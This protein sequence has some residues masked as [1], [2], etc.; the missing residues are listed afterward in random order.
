[1]NAEEPSLLKTEVEY[2]IKQLKANKSPGPD[3]I[4]PEIL[5]LISEENIDLLVAL[6]NRIYETGKI[7]QEWSGMGTREALFSLL[8]L[9]QKC[10]DQQRDIFIC[11]IDFEKAFDRVR[12]DLLIESLRGVG[13][14]EKDNA[15]IQNLYCNQS[16]RIRIEGSKSY[17][18]GIEF[19]FDRALADI[20]EGVKVNGVNINSIRYADDTILIADS[21]VG[22]QRLLDRVSNTCEEFDMKIN[23]KKT[24][25]I[26]K[27]KIEGK[28]GLGRKKLSRLRNIL[29]CDNYK[30][31]PS[32]LES[33]ADVVY[34][35]GQADSRER[36][37]EMKRA[38]HLGFRGRTLRAEKPFDTIP[39]KIILLLQPGYPFGLTKTLRLIQLYRTLSKT[40]QARAPSAWGPNG[41]RRRPSGGFRRKRQSERA[42]APPFQHPSHLKFQLARVHVCK[43]S[44]GY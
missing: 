30:L 35:G 31:R 3:E 12:H 5:K 6:Y 36:K 14:D 33:V 21:D 24:K 15:L 13:L 19:T 10:Y 25:L 16:A 4:L 9:A 17:Q 29:V 28:R 11:L 37:N 20:S 23:V 43:Y 1:M 42:R 27:G 7:L 38:W 44:R 32:G 8:V 26:V 22:L 40:Q 18:L 39:N 2:A 34:P 41:R